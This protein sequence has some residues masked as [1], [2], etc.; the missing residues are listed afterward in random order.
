MSPRATLRL[1][2]SGYAIS[3]FSV[4]LLAIPAWEEAR[5]HPALFACLLGGCGLSIVGQLMRYVANA[6]DGPKR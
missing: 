2:L 6:A 3:I 4:V 5:K 1:K